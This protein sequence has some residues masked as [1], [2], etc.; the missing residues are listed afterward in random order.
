MKKAGCSAPI[1]C[2]TCLKARDDD[3]KACKV[4]CACCTCVPKKDFAKC[5]H[6][7][8]VAPAE[9]EAALPLDNLI[10]AAVGA[11]VSNKSKRRQDHLCHLRLLHE[12]SFSH[13]APAEGEAAVPLDKPITTA[14]GESLGEAI[15][16]ADDRN[17]MIPLRIQINPRRG[18]IG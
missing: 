10:V 12:N 14:V 3:R 4:C 13:A 11:K 18:T 9:G 8:A 5:A 2:L 17:F 6:L 16:Y 15:A 7:Y 1:D